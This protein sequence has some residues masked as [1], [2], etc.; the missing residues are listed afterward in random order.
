MRNEFVNLLKGENGYREGQNADGTWNNHQKY[1]EETPGLEWS[2]WQAWCAT[3]E[4]WG[5]HKEGMDGRWPMTASCY[6]AVQYWQDQNRWTPYPVLGGPAY[7]G[8]VGQDHTAVVWKYDDNWIW[9]AE[10]N[11]N[12][13]G[14][15]NGNGVYLRQRPRRGAGSPY[16]YGVPNY[17]EGTISADPSL[18]GTSQAEVPGPSVSTP[19]PVQPSGAAYPGFFL[20]RT[21]PMM[22][23][24]SVR[25]LQTRLSNR[26]WNIG[27]DGWFGDQTLGVVE[28]F[29]QRHGLTRDGIVGPLTWAAIFGA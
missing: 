16:G 1:S 4:A 9:T 26:G 3:F 7:F 6:T 8:S 12:N 13:D 5:A 18:G 2:D 22:H 11:T 29:Q 25:L 17:P 23:N 19:P 28:A 15:S 20:R 27:I 10:G 21:T 14:S 24:D